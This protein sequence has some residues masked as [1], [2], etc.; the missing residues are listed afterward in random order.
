M[1]ETLACLKRLLLFW[2]PYDP[3]EHVDE[4]DGQGEDGEE[5][6]GVK[7]KSVRPQIGRHEN[8]S[9][10]LLFVNIGSSCCQLL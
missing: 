10:S 4:E 2:P 3:A 9:P 8:L 1:L 5:A 7:D 6:D